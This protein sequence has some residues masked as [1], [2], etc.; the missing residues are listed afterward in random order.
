MG[1]S[2]LADGLEA[3][4]AASLSLRSR[5]VGV[6]CDDP[7][8]AEALLLQQAAASLGA[9]AALVRPDLDAASGPAELA[10]TARVL[11]RL[12]D[13]ILCVDLAPSIV[14]ALSETAG[15]PVIA[16]DVAQW[17]ARRST[18][19]DALDDARL[20]LLGQLAAL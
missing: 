5:N 7:W 8:R 10:H 3:S 12:Y 2:P 19:S 20:F 1:A 15:V 14:A 6:L 11:G 4:G 13:A 9:R 17:F 18:T 16:N